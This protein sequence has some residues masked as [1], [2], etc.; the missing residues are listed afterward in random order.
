M[1]ANIP[2]HLQAKGSGR[3]LKLHQLT[4]A[5]KIET[6]LQMAEMRIAKQNA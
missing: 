4:K 6:Q 1:F 5:E 3:S 2:A